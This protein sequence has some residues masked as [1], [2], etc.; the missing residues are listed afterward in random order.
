MQISI[1]LLNRKDTFLSSPEWSIVP[2]ELHPKSH[3][4]RLFDITVLL[5]S[6]FAR[7]DRIFPLPATAT[8][9]LKAVDLLANSLNIER[10]LDEWLAVA[11]QPDEDYPQAFWIEEPDAADASQIPFADSFA[12]KDGISSIMFLHYWMSLMLFHRCVESLHSAIFQPV[13]DA[14]P[15]MYP[16]L[17]PNLQIDPAKYQ[18]VRDLASNICRSLDSALNITTQPDML[19]APL[20]VVHEF[21]REINAVSRDG[22]LEMLWCERFKTRLMAKGQDIADVIQSKEWASLGS[23]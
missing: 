7:A 3:L 17:P 20:T 1:A 18:Q 21:Y 23:F 14:Y 13:I 6:I 2:W 22:E 19:V 12:F 16:N 15:D 10:Q 11:T 9:R 5:P 4:D 8:R